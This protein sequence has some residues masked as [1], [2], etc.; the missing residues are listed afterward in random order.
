MPSRIWRAGSFL[1]DGGWPK[2]VRRE[3]LDPEQVSR[4]LNDLTQ[5][6]KGAAPMEIGGLLESLSIQFWTQDFG[7]DE[8]RALARQWAEDFAHVP[9]DI[10]AE[11]CRIWRRTETW[12]PK[13]AELLAVVKP[14]LDRRRDA[15]KHATAVHNALNRAPKQVEAAASNETEDELIERV[16]ARSRA[17]RE[18]H[19]AEIAAEHTDPS[20]DAQRALDWFK[21]PRDWKNAP[22]YARG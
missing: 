14:L 22:R 18:R 5:S 8:A 13:P 12:F 1:I 15:L 6:L 10:L 20:S 7:R 19:R 17:L 2:D 11:A 3:D 9:G 4:L 16:L 21:K